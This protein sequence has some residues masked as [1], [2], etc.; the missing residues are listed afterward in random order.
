MDNTDPFHSAARVELGT[1]DS[2]AP[3]Q[4][5][6]FSIWFTAHSSTGTYTTDWRML[7]E[8]VEWF[9]DTDLKSV[10]VKDGVS[11]NLGTSNINNNLTCPNDGDG[12]NTGTTIGGVECRKNTNTG[13]DYFFY[14]C[15]SDS[16]A[17]QGSKQ[18]VYIKL[19]Y[20]DTGGGTIELNYDAIGNQWKS[21][22]TVTLGT[23]NTWKT[24]TWHV[25]DAYF[26]NRTSGADMRF[27]IGTG[28]TR[29]FD[30]VQVSTGSL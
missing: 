10:Q 30:Q 14:F 4:Q 9:G 19:N 27:F 15:V 22:G 11:I 17:Y 2:I 20:Y 28:V 7:R 23:T 24:Y 21:G 18:D 25:T 16:W 6:A 13:D 3:T 26:G 8:N 1:G 5:K 12:H 29:Y